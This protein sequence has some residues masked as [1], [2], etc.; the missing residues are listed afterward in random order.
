VSRDDDEFVRHVAR[1]LILYNIN[2]NVKI[3]PEIIMMVETTSPQSSLKNSKGGHHCYKAA[4]LNTYEECIRFLSSACIDG[5]QAS[6]YV[7]KNTSYMKLYR[8]P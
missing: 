1:H 4:D 6:K 5:H 3:R 2:S 8:A 7:I